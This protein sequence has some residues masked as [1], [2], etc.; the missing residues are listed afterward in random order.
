M[1]LCVGLLIVTILDR[2]IYLALG[3]EF[4][5]GVKGHS[6]Y[7]ALRSVG[8]LPAWIVPAVALMLVDRRRGVSGIASSIARRW[9]DRGLLL[10]AGTFFSGLVA[11][12]LKLLH[13]RDRPLDGGLY[14]WEGPWMADAHP[15]GLPSS[16]MAVAMGGALVL[17]RLFPE[18]R[19]LLFGLAVGC[20]ATRV[21]SRAHFA[22]DV[23]AGA[24][25]AWGM[26]VVVGRVHAWRL[27]RTGAREERGGVK[28]SRHGPEKGDTL[29]LEKTSRVA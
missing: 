11:E 15:A 18:M 9:W 20:G 24:L 26:V 3:D 19:W 7:Q 28:A 21:A 8:W 16:H 2:P 12:G 4:S 5:E 22:S 27:A 13:L 14:E 1:V 6:V 10:L 17:A 23:Y 29:T 25:V